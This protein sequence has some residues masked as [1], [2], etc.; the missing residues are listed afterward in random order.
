MSPEVSSRSRAHHLNG[1]DMV[2]QDT[3]GWDLMKWF[4]NH[5]PEKTRPVLDKVIK[6]LKDQG[7]TAFGAT[8]YC[9]GG[10]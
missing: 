5:G 6:A 8:G 10:K 3:T 7:V 4:P 1:S 9:F 2:S